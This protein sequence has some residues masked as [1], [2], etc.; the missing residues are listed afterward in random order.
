VLVDPETLATLPER[1]LVAGL[2]EVVKYGLIELSCTGE[3]GFFDWLLTHAGN[4]RLALSE[5]IDRCCRIKAAVVM[6]DETETLGLRYY[7]NLGHTFGH[8]YESLSNYSLLHGEAVAIG[9]M[10]AAELSFARGEFSLGCLQ[11][12]K[13]L[14]QKL[15]LWGL[16]GQAQ[17]FAPAALLNRMTRD[18]KNENGRIRLVLPVQEPGRVIVCDDVPESDILRVLS[19]H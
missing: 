3:G 18:K 12:L 16:M 11:R 15:G 5:L 19:A 7:L 13:T 17:C 10:K 14:F 8:A 1:E 4:P 9:V 2:A 6:Q